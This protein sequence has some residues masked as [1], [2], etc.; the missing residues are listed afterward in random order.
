MFK[1]IREFF[2][3]TCD[4][5]QHYS[6]Y[7]EPDDLLP[8]KTA[9]RGK[10][11]CESCDKMDCRLNDLKACEMFQVRSRTHNSFH[12]FLIHIQG[13]SRIVPPITGSSIQP[14]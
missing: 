9:V 3:K 13:H 7:R 6:W 2:S 10:M 1:R 8:D 14:K 4:D 12:A 5:C 11:I